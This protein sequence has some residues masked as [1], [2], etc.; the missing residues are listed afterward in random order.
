MV[1]RYQQTGAGL[2][3]TPTLTL[4]TNQTY[5]VNLIR[6]DCPQLSSTHFTRQ[7][8][9]DISAMKSSS[10][11]E[12]DFI[13]SKCLVLM[14]IKLQETCVRSRCFIVLSV[15]QTSQT[16]ITHGDWRVQPVTRDVTHH[17]S[18]HWSRSSC[19]G[20]LFVHNLTDLNK[21]LFVTTSYSAQECYSVTFLQSPAEFVV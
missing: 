1:I 21:I 15:L 16:M 20:Y 9:A 10:A 7:L 14:E 11:E 12:I 2:Q 17:S 13:L 19:S 4:R 8:K 6:I 5:N 3:S 18:L